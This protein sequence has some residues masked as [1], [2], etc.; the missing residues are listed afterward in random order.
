MGA[1]Y[2]ITEKAESQNQRK[3]E[4][5]SQIYQSYFNKTGGKKFPIDEAVLTGAIDEIAAFI[6]A[7]RVLSYDILAQRPYYKPFL[8]EK[9]MSFTAGCDGL[10]NAMIVPFRELARAHCITIEPCHL[11]DPKD[12]RTVKAYTVA[13]NLHTFFAAMQLSARDYSGSIF[14]YKEG[15]EAY[16]SRLYEDGR[17]P[18]EDWI[19]AD[20]FL[21][22]LERRCVGDYP[23]HKILF[24]YPR[25]MV[26]EPFQTIIAAH[27]GM[28]DKHF[29]KIP[30]SIGATADA[31]K[32][33]DNDLRKKAVNALYTN[34]RNMV[35][36]RIEAH[37]SGDDVLDDDTYNGF[38]SAQKHFSEKLGEGKKKKSKVFGIL[39]WF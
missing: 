5:L 26:I 39:P 23:K 11:A 9:V 1:T 22:D 28:I 3:R 37:E 33:Q 24:Q 2:N 7:S 18:V 20:T 30:R 4:E 8:D 25:K 12:A 14:S 27:E 35:S 15:I 36:R 34:A 31:G 29:P 21:T 17:L 38:T 16:F 6:D 13:G 32:R 10:M 19:A